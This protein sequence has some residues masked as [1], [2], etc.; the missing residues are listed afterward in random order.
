MSG[1]AEVCDKPKTTL[2]EKM[3]DGR[4]PLGQIGSWVKQ[5]AKIESKKIIFRILVFM[6]LWRITFL[7]FQNKLAKFLLI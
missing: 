2:A 3:S 5:T 6:S 7:K 4:L 1:V